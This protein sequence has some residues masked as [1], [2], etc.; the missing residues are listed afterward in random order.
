MYLDNVSKSSADIPIDT[1]IIATMYNLTELLLFL[2]YFQNIQN[3]VIIFRIPG[4]Y[5][6]IEPKM[7]KPTL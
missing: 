7:L 6:N 2:T 1:L 3:I 4:I 5:P